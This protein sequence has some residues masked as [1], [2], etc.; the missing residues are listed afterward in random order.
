MLAFGFSAATVQ[1]GNFERP[2][3]VIRMG[4]PPV[5]I[6]PD[7]VGNW[8]RFFRVLFAAAINNDRRR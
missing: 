7:Y 6:D 5:C 3:Q 4:V 8:R 2:N 1:A